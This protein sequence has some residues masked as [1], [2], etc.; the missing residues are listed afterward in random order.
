MPFKQMN[1]S[2]ALL[3]LYVVLGVVLHMNYDNALSLLL[4]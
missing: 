4:A 3:L 1:Y 2:I